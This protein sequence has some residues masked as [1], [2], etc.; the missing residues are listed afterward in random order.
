[1]GGQLTKRNENMLTKRRRFAD[2][3]S[4]VGVIENI[5]SADNDRQGLPQNEGG[6]WRQF[7]ESEWE[8][9]VAF[10]MGLAP[11]L[12]V[13]GGMELLREHG[14]RVMDVLD[15]ARGGWGGEGGGEGGVRGRW[16]RQISECVE[17]SVIE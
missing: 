7:Y 10:L 5:V 6:G 2:V 9:K 16:R 1:M 15:V 11:S 14:G 12:S 3:G 4:I 13:L 8:G 17:L